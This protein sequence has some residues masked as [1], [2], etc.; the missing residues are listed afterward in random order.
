MLTQTFMIKYYKKNMYNKLMTILQ[1]K[2]YFR[3]LLGIIPAVILLISFSCEEEPNSLGTNILPDDDKLNYYY[4]TSMIF[5]STV[6]DKKEFATSS[7]T[8]YPLGIVDDEYFGVFKSSFA[9]QFLPKELA[10]SIDIDLSDVDSA[11]LSIEIDTIFGSSSNDQKFIVYELSEELE[12]SSFHTYYSNENI[13]NYYLTENIISTDCTIVDDTLLRFSLT[14]EFAAKFVTNE[15]SINK[16]HDYFKSIF[17]GLAIIPDTYTDE[18]QTMLTDPFA[19]YSKIT[20]YY[21]DSLTI[22]YVFTYGS[23]FANITYSKEGE[24]FSTEY[25][26]SLMFFQNMGG[27]S[28]RI[29][30]TNYKD[31]YNPDS[32]YS[33]L[34][35]EIC[36]PVVT[37]D[38]FDEFPHPSNLFFHYTDADSNLIAIQDYSSASVNTSLFGKFDS[39]NLSYTIN[40]TNHFQDLIDGNIADSCLSLNM[41]STYAYPYRVILKSND[42]IKLRVTYTKH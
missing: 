13:E 29:E 30:F 15:D 31:I 28:S 36:L 17:Y 21:S 25:N 5:K 32:I 39:T 38:N 26:D 2:N 35:A 41:E 1:P 18:G 9:S 3:Y 6:Y 10:E 12:D 23:K 7:L 8:K 4:D 34:N 33:I 42:H 20:L 27:A 11:I 40:I 14:P 19:E 37:P 16:T 22:D 24:D